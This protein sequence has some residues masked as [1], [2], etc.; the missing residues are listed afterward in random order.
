MQLKLRVVK[1]WRHVVV[2]LTDGC[3]PSVDG[4]PLSE[5]VPEP[6]VWFKV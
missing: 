1:D 4:C 6:G 2:T 5:L 3:W